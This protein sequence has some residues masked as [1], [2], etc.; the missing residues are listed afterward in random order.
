[1]LDKKQAKVIFDATN[2]SSGMF[3]IFYQ[4]LSEAYSSL[5]NLEELIGQV[6]NIINNTKSVMFHI[7]SG[8]L[9]EYK[10]L[11]ESKEALKYVYDVAKQIEGLIDTKFLLPLASSSDQPMQKICYK[12]TKADE[13]VLKTKARVAG[14]KMFNLQNKLLKQEQNENNIKNKL[15]DKFSKKLAEATTNFVKTNA[16]KTI[17][18]QT[19]EFK[20]SLDKWKKTQLK[21][22]ENKLKNMVPNHD[23]SFAFRGKNIKKISPQTGKQQAKELAEKIVN[24]VYKKRLKIF[25]KF[26]KQPTGWHTGNIKKAFNYNGEMECADWT[27]LFYSG[28]EKPIEE[29]YSVNLNSFRVEWRRYPPCFYHQGEHSYIRIVGTS[30]YLVIDPWASGGEKIVPKK[31]RSASATGVKNN[32]YEDEQGKPFAYPKEY[33]ENFV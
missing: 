22:L 27:A 6:L 17:D 8:S 5:S 31:E 33:V 1:M 24:L 15:Q 9:Y 21:I 23:Y 13:F 19:A 14:E 29:Y 4:I 20:K 11:K 32:I 18:K 3:D 12:M 10:P 25:E 30:G 7:K 16:S 2:Q 26:K 28:L